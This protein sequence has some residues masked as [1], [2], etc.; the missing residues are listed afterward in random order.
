MS[1]FR[2]RATNT[3]LGQ[4]ENSDFVF[5][6]V[7][8]DDGADVA[9]EILFPPKDTVIVKGARLTELQCIANAR[10]LLEME[11]VWL[12]DGKPLEE[13]GIGFSFNDLWNRTLS[14][15]QADS[16]YEGTYSC[17]VRMRTGGPT[18]TKEAKVT[19]IGKTFYYYHHL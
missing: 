15:F 11:L 6:E 19:V 8:D 17:E 14:L 18:M 16:T 9:P 4:D 3:Q 2:A 13:A 5:L 1:N 12:K 10:P 7:T